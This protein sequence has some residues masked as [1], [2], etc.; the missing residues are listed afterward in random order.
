MCD[1]IKRITE[2]KLWFVCAGETPIRANKKKADLSVGLFPIGAQ[3][4][5]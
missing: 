5:T 3:E 2:D 4:R 1:A